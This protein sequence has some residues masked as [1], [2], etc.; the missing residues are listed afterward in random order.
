MVN[1]KTCPHSE[2]DRIRISGTMVRKS[3]EEGKMPPAE[4]MR[5]EVARAIISFGDPFVR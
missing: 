4:V 2:D 3:L 5:P 1:E